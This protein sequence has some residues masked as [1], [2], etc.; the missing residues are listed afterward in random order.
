MNKEIDEYCEEQRRKLKFY[1]REVERL[2]ESL[3]FPNKV[4]FDDEYRERYFR[5]LCATL[6]WL[7]KN[8]FT[9]SESK[10]DM[11]QEKAEMMT[12][13]DVLDFCE[14]QEDF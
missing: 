10:E 8:H 12:A 4:Y 11:F 13:Q 1:V 9:L 3:D 7:K 14:R 6:R 5:N 2:R